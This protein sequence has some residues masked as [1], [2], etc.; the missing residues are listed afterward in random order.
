MNLGER[1]YKRSIHWGVKPGKCSTTISYWAANNLQKSDVIEMPKAK[2]SRERGRKWHTQSRVHL[3]SDRKRDG[4]EPFRQTRS[5]TPPPTSQSGRSLWLDAEPEA[6]VRPSLSCCSSLCCCIN[7]CRAGL[8]QMTR[9]PHFWI[10]LHAF[11][12][13]SPF[14]TA[15]HRVSL[16]RESGRIHSPSHRWGKRGLSLLFSLSKILKQAQILVIDSFF[17]LPIRMFPFLLPYL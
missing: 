7:S 8:L 12:D 15:L 1:D 4:W 13:P 17:F 9:L 16:T 5:S 2:T 10:L 14:S 11:R 6:E 3:P